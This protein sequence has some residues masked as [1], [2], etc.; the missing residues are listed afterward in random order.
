MFHFQVL[1]TT[2][3]MP[4][5][6]RQQL[7]DRNLHASQEHRQYLLILCGKI[8][9]RYPQNQ[10]LV[11]KPPAQLLPS[12]GKY[13]A[14][15]QHGWAGAINH[16]GNKEF[17]IGD[18]LNWTAWEKYLIK[19]E[20]YFGWLSVLAYPTI[21]Q[22]CFLF[23][24]FRFCLLFEGRRKLIEILGDK[25]RLAFPISAAFFLITQISFR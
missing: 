19:A 1:T 20:R 3:T 14:Y 22:F 18:R 9:F 4:T 16:K 6:C 23:S 15:I 11:T 25:R 21:L 24:T 10:A 17:E 12:F 2:T 5:G 13:G 7:L 8:P